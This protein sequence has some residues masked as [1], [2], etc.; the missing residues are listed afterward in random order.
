M[1]DVITVGPAAV[2][3]LQKANGRDV[4]LINTGTTL[5][6]LSDRIN[7]SPSYGIPLQA[8]YGITW[9]QSSE[10]FAVSPSGSGTLVVEAAAGPIFATGV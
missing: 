5:V 7:V 3:V 10:C 6:Y 8:K 9:D 4:M 2:Q 1:T